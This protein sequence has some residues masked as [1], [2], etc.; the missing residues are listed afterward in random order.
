MTRYEQF[1]ALKEE[2]NRLILCVQSTAMAEEKARQLDNDEAVDKA[3][4]LGDTYREELRE[5]RCKLDKLD[6]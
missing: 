4:A 6:F 2:E 1:K 3:V 5:V